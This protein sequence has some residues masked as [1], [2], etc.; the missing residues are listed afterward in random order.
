MTLV[1]AFTGTIGAVMCGDR[2]EIRFYEGGDV[3]RL[4]YELYNGLIKTDNELMER[5][6]DLGVRIE[7][8]D[9]KE[10][11]FTSDD[12]LVGRVTSYSAETEQQRRMYVASGGYLIAE[13]VDGSVRVTETGGSAFLVLGNEMTKKI[14]G[15]VIGRAKKPERLS[16]VVLVLMRAMESVSQKTASVSQAYDMMQIQPLQEDPGRML[17]KALEQDIKQNHWRML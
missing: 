2:R 4:E 13:I 1:I 3:E 14:S 17:Q 7:I 11:I 8:R 12:I 16:D 6:T 10:K 5:S 9:D 15:E